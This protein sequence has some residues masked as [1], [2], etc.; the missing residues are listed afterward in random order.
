[1]QIIV[2]DI[3]RRFGLFLSGNKVPKR[4]SV[5]GQFWKLCEEFEKH[6]PDFPF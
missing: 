3:L 5:F 6:L 4:R 1:M 2:N